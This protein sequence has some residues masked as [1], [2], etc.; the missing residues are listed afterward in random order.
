[1]SLPIKIN[2]VF[3]FNVLK[4]QILSLPKSPYRT[5]KGSVKRAAHYNNNLGALQSLYEWLDEDGRLNEYLHQLNLTL[6]EGNMVYN[7]LPQLYKP[8]SPTQQ[9]WNER[10]LDGYSTMTHSKSLDSTPEYRKLREII[11]QTIGKRVS[12]GIGYKEKVDW[13]TQKCIKF[14][15]F[16]NEK[17]TFIEV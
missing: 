12:K 13:N 8:M 7:H 16:D 1:M 2:L 9:N 17:Q 15:S 3:G 6:E 5:D 14:Y 10:A 4:G 11:Y